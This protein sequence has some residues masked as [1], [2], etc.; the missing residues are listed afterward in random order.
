MRCQRFEGPYRHVFTWKGHTDG[1]MDFRVFVFDRDVPGTQD[2]LGDDFFPISEENCDWGG[3][4]AVASTCLPAVPCGCVDGVSACQHHG[5]F[6]DVYAMIA[7][8]RRRHHQVSAGDCYESRQRW[9]DVP[10]LEKQSG[11]RLS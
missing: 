6:A 2:C 4:V 3:M 10:I 1:N 7:V 9:F 5:D 8:V 11:R